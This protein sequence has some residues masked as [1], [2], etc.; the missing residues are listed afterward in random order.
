[1][2]LGVLQ[3]KG[4][5]GKT[6]LALNLAAYFA[7]EGARTLLVDADPQGSALAWSQ[8]REAP[9]R[10]PVIGMPKP[11]LHKELPAVAKDYDLVV[12][13][14]APRVNELA[15]SAILSADFIL[16]PVQP[17]PFDIWSCADIVTLIREAQS[18]KPINAAFVINRRIANTAIG[19]DVVDAIRQFEFPVLRNAISQR[20]AFAEAAAVGLTVFETAAAGMAAREIK[21]I[22]KEI[23]SL[24]SER[25]AA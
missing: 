5:A 18:L 23:Q 17:S 25:K 15:R 2:I 10:F 13:D 6:T 14:G 12:I 16:I 8:V 20:I 4:G 21:A 3:Q 22:A 9:P 1:M 11:T 24:Q 7:G 19:R